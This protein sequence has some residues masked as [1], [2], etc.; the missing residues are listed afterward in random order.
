MYK[1]SRIH[2]EWEDQLPGYRGLPFRPS[3]SPAAHPSSSPSNRD[4]ARVG[5][6]SSPSSGSRGLNKTSSSSSQQSDSFPVLPDPRSFPSYSQKAPATPAISGT[7]TTPSSAST[8][9]ASQSRAT[10]TSQVP[11]T[12]TPASSVSASKH[13][14]SAA[15]H[16]MTANRNM[17]GST[18]YRPTG[19]SMVTPQSTAKSTFGSS[20][21]SSASKHQQPQNKFSLPPVEESNAKMPS[22]SSASTFNTHER[23]EPSAACLSAATSQNLSNPTLSRPAAPV[24]FT[25]VGG[26]STAATTL[27]APVASSSA[28]PDPPKKSWNTAR[29]RALAKRREMLEKRKAQ[30]GN[31][32]DEDDDGPDDGPPSQERQGSTPTIAPVPPVTSTESASSRPN[33]QSH[34]P[35]TASNL[36]TTSRSSQN[37]S[38]NLVRR[39]SDHLQ[40]TSQGSTPTRSLTPSASQKARN[41]VIAP[42]P[43]EMEELVKPSPPVKLPD[44]SLARNMPKSSPT[45]APAPLVEH[46]KRKA[47]LTVEEEQTDKRPKL[48]TTTS[49][50]SVRSPSTHSS[51]STPQTE[52]HSPHASNALKPTASLGSGSTSAAPNPVHS[53]PS[54]VM[55]AQTAQSSFNKAASPSTN[56]AATRRSPFNIPKGAL[57]QTN[58]EQWQYIAEGGANMV[59]GYVGPPSDF[60]GKALRIRKKAPVEMAGDVSKQVKSLETNKYWHEKLLPHVLGVHH[61][62]GKE[63]L[64]PSSRLH[65]VDPRW[66]YKLEQSARPHRPF[67]RTS[68]VGAT[69]ESKPELASVVLADNM[70]GGAGYMSVEIKPKCGFVPTGESLDAAVK[71]TKT[72]ACKFC[73]KRCVDRSKGDEEDEFCPIDLFSDQ[74]RSRRV[75]L[76]TLAHSWKKGKAGNNMRVF[77]DGKLAKPTIHQAKHIH[78]I[79][80]HYDPL[81]IAQQVED[82]LSSSQILTTLLALQKQFEDPNG[83][84]RTLGGYVRERTNNSSAPFPSEYTQEVDSGELIR[85]FGRSEPVSAANFRTRCVSYAIA[86]IFKDCSI[87][88]R[89]PLDKVNEP[90]HVSSCK[91]QLADLDLKPMSKLNKWYEQDQTLLTTTHTQGWTI[92]CGAGGIKGRTDHK[93]L[94]PL[95][96]PN[97]RQASG[98][99]SIASATG[100]SRS[101]PV[102]GKTLPTK[103]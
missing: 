12:P 22:N 18:P 67:H 57:E 25:H 77:V 89:W 50:T 17:T 27:P 48:N 30:A 31:G 81:W 75:A 92:L 84:I 70:I 20:T 98:G 99:R 95:P 80:D 96:D 35:T 91:V 43:W 56:D 42:P 38:S 87:I 10:P 5:P 102:I 39:P 72:K 11:V 32:S 101:S 41:P 19:S 14:D 86:S 78:A 68:G 24:G 61:P 13:A 44:T 93:V 65:D 4:A 54:P 2:T 49:Q 103:R 52:I 3:S 73:Q 33:S 45:P 76:Q 37:S 21:A 64:A 6:P 59:F 26:E 53:A 71:S 66:L 40:S 8:I 36:A 29:E 74:F 23:P 1:S 79:G 60:T 97:P 69:L 94:T 28:A 63:F 51:V 47:S 88:L 46:G 9:R 85:L 58:S 83:D 7:R 16:D 55:P 62:R 90:D 82:V 15:S 100:P 34:V